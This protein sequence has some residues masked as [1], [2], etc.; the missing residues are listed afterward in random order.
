MFLKPQIIDLFIEDVLI[1]VVG[2][3]VVILCVV[4]TKSGHDWDLREVLFKHVSYFF[5]GVHELMV[6]SLDLFRVKFG[7]PLQINRDA[8]TNKITWSQNEV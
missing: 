1:L 7:V 3:L 2:W 5:V 4:V 6:A 8:M